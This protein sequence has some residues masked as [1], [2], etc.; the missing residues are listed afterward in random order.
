[1]NW[2]YNI[3]IV[4]L[5]KKGGDLGWFGRGKMVFEFQNIA[6]ST[7]VGDVSDIFKTEHGYH[8]LLVEGRRN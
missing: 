6:F 8:I 1:V 5:K 7:K 2:H 3:V 4:L